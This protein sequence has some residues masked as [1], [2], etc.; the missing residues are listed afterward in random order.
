MGLHGSSTASL[1]FGENDNCYGWMIGEGPVDGRGKGMRQMFQ[2]MNEERLNTGTFSL[3]CI[4]QLITQ[5]WII[6]KFGYRAP[7]G[8]IPRDQ[9][10]L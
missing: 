1:A 7:S 3:G 9:A 10:F 2:M 5:L 8:V 6:V 4:G